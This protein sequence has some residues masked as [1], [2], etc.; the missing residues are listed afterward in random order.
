MG[1]RDQ[2]NAGFRA[3]TFANTSSAGRSPVPTSR[4]PARHHS[5]YVVELRPGAARNPAFARANSQR[6]DDKPCLYVG[7]TGLSPEQRFANHLA[8]IRAARIVRKFGVRLRP[9]LYARFNPMSYEEAKAMER[10]LAR[11]LRK[12]GF[13]V[14]QR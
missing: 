11:R 4:H 10:E 14:W 3:T 8:G 5:V 9:K 12:K 1:S 13:G 6:R 7:L 2:R